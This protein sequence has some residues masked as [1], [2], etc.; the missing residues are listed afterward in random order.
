LTSRIET[1]RP[2]WLTALAVVC[3]AAFVINVVR[4]LLFP[5]LRYTEVWFGFEV[6]GMAALVTAPLHWLIFA[7]GAWACWRRLP[8]AVPAASAYLFYV[9]FSH[10]VWSEVSSSGRGWQIGLSQAAG[11]ALFGMLLLYARRSEPR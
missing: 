2:W 4:D 3:A 5:E 11:I 6:T 1:A 9:A 7:V 10:L 8:W